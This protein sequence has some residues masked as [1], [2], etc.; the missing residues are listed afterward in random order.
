MQARTK[1]KMIGSALAVILVASIAAI[2]IGTAPP[3]QAQGAGEEAAHQ[4]GIVLASRL[5]VRSGPGVTY[6]ALGDLKQ[7]D[8]VEVIGRQGSWLQIVY[9]A[10]ASGTGWVRSAY[11]R[12]GGNLASS[13]QVTA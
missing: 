10:S 2:G 3:A 5:N 13:S 6:S 9:S 11:V 8:R 1:N 4:I 7:G 12:V